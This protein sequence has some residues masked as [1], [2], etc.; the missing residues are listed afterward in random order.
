LKPHV[1]SPH[2]K[3]Q[4]RFQ[5]RSESEHFVAFT[6]NLPLPCFEFGRK[7]HRI[8]RRELGSVAR[9]Q[10]QGVPQVSCEVVLSHFIPS[11]NSPTQMHEAPSIDTSSRRLPVDQRRENR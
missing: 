1:K 4:P 7:A 8:S 3:L 6:P 11:R 9:H 2:I 5:R 10:P